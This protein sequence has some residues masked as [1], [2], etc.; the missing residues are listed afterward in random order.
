MSFYKRFLSLILT[1]LCCLTAGIADAQQNFP[2][3]ANLRLTPP[4]SLY[5]N[6]YTAPGAQK[7]QLDLFLK[8]LT[9]QNYPFRLR[10]KI[11]GFGITIASRPDF[12]V[13]PFYLNA[14]EM[15]VMYGD[16]LATY[17]DPANL[18]FQG[19]DLNTFQSRGGKLPEGVY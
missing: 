1:S 16:E 15:R 17:L 2:I 12:Y 13:A 14:G 9:K 7:L 5:L 11:E 10:V 4:Y 19:I 6:D 8:D 18:V 3:L